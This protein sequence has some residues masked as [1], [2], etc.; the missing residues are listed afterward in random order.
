M[1]KSDRRSDTA[2]LG[3]TLF[4]VLATFLALCLGAAAPVRAQPL[5]CPGNSAPFPANTTICTMTIKIFNDDPDNYVWPVLET[6][7]AVF[8]QWM[9]AWF[10][11]TNAD[12]LPTSQTYKPY[13]R[14]HTYRLYINP[15]FGLPPHTGVQIT[16]PL[17]TLLA[18]QIDV[19]P[20]PPCTPGAS[21]CPADTFAEWWSGGNIQLYTSPVPQ[22]PPSLVNALLSKT[23]IE[24]FAPPGVGAVLPTCTPIASKIPGPTPLCEPLRIIRDQAG[25]QK[26]DGSQLIEYTLG[27]KNANISPNPIAY[28]LDTHNVDFDVS[29]VNVIWAPAVMGVFGNDQV[30]YTG[31]DQT[32]K[33][34][35]LGKNGDG[36][37]GLTNFQT[38]MAT[39]GWPQFYN[40]F[41]NIPAGFPL[42]PNL[43][44]QTLLKFPSPL[45]I[46]GRLGGV[47][48]PPDLAPLLDSTVWKSTAPGQGPIGAIQQKW[49]PIY[50]LYNNW[51]TYAG[52][53]TPSNPPN[54]TPYYIATNGV[55]GA[56]PSTPPTTPITDWC[57]AVVNAKAIL[58][59]NYAKYVQ[60]FKGQCSGLPVTISNQLLMGHLYG[61]TP[62]TEA[63][64]N[65]DGSSSGTGCP[66]TI[67]LLEN[68]PGGYCVD[69]PN[70]PAPA[71]PWP[72]P[73]C[74]TIADPVGGPA[75]GRDYTAYITVKHGFDLLNDD[76]L[77]NLRYSFNPYVAL[78]H[79]PA[80]NLGIT[81]AYAYSV[82]D[83]LGNVQAEGKGFII[84]V[85]SVA[86]LE[87][88][89]PCSEPINIT[90]GYNNPPFSPR[91]Y[92][93]AV[94][95]ITD[96]VPFDRVKPVIPGF[97][98]FIIS[99]QN[100][101]QCPIILWD[102][103]DADNRIVDNDPSGPPKGNMYTFLVNTLGDKASLDAA[104][105]LFPTA[106]V[107]PV[108]TSVWATIPPPS[109]K[110]P[111]VYPN[112]TAAIWC[113]TNSII[114]N[115]YSSQMWCC[116]SLL[117]RNPKPTDGTGVFSFRQQIL[118]AHSTQQ[119]VANTNPAVKAC[120][121]PSS[122]GLPT[123]NFTPCNFGQ[124]IQ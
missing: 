26:N 95:K 21:N 59:Q 11:V 20:Q 99:A 5:A 64:L 82:D 115:L 116:T 84:D 55:C 79:G 77:N 98:S 73:P 83:A 71:P 121:S 2:T 46:F 114:G 12:T 100:P 4:L 93:Y 68:S 35:R 69:L 66:A 56:M 112:T 14:Y 108:T 38:A 75:A 22:Q 3:C 72:K 111:P 88:P 110:P 106:S 16:L 109:Y 17:Y 119:Y 90:L 10:S 30:G 52:T 76:T 18:P 19:N 104:F 54:Q 32:T 51:T 74:P 78:I 57:A 89:N 53:V 60:I 8:D 92:K 85:A 124:P 23:Q 15:S 39:M 6:G 120:N 44:P 25:L 102:Q 36:K 33:T 62:W 67:N 1:T 96:T 117:T 42:F 13:P 50:A 41:P 49:P 47:D 122:C 27:A 123:P 97:A 61:W 34:F 7:Q 9:Q 107:P 24:V 28:W 86:N 48:P 70:P 91:F 40:T 29:Y 81:C 113:K 43:M 31:T 65:A 118:S 45:E 80:P 94:C 63:A 105:P 103:I 101:S 37:G 87:N 58:L